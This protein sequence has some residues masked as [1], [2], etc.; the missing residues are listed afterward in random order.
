MT[1]VIVSKMDS[2]LSAKIVRKYSWNYPLSSKSI[3]LCAHFDDV[4]GEIA[5]AK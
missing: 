5:K 2:N 3:H 4:F 1:T